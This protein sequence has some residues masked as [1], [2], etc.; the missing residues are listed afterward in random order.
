MGVIL[1]ELLVFA[2]V[3]AHRGGTMFLIAGD[4]GV[5]ARALREDATHERRDLPL[6][7]VGEPNLMSCDV[8]S[9]PSS[10]WCDQRNAVIESPHISAEPRP[11]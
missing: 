11:L 8:I 9:E 10:R 5:E 6:V 2:E 7:A 1:R 3:G 4:R